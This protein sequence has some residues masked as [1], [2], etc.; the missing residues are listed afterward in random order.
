MDV[1]ALGLRVLLVEDD[2]RL[3]RLVETYLQSHRVV[4]DWV[5][6]GQQALQRGFASTMDLVLLDLMLPGLGGLQVC[7]RIRERSD[8]PIIMLTAR[9]EEGD[10]VLGLESGADDYVPKPFSARELLARIRAQV[11]RHRGQAGPVVGFMQ[12]GPVAVDPSARAAS[13]NGVPLELT[14]SEFDL[15][16][17]LVSRAGR[18]LSREVLLDLTRGSA[19]ETFDRAIDVHISRLRHKLGEDP[20]RPRWLK[21]VRG[22]GYMFALEASS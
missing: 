13:M 12:V 7:R 19:E 16:H 15:L 5:R 11:R 20:R 1:D 21:T 10:R 2:E 14:S 8:V 18:V 3:G 22:S 17:A 6:D 9:G 4:V